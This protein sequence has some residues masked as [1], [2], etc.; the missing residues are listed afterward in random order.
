M[1]Y[2]WKQVGRVPRVLKCVPNKCIDFMT[3]CIIAHKK[4]GRREGKS[5]GRLLAESEDG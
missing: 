4:Y 3:S 2:I 5:A 1:V